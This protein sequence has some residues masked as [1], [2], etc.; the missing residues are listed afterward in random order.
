MKNTE[1]YEIYRLPVFR[2][3]DIYLLVLSWHQ[4]MPC[5]TLTNAE[6]SW[7]IIKVSTLIKLLQNINLSD[8]ITSIR[9]KQWRFKQT[10]GEDL[11]GMSNCILHKD[12]I[13]Y[14]LSMQDIFYLYRTYISKKC[15]KHIHQKCIWSISCMHEVALSVQI[16]YLWCAVWNSYSTK[17]LILRIKKVS[18]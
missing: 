3:G 1:Y 8:A 5:W 17:H 9:P 14:C 4:V 16:W 6:R 15:P 2:L 13:C 7:T 12:Q 18:N 11:A 10:A